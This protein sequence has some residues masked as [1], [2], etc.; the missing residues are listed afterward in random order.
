MATPAEME[1][2]FWK[3]LKSDMTMMLG[4]DGVEDGHTRPMTAQTEEEGGPIWFFTSKDNGIV[5]RLSGT[6][7]A[8]ATF[9]SKGHDL[10]ATV[11]GRLGLELDRAV[12]DRLW[13]P[14]AAAWYEEGK[15]DPKLALLRLDPEQAEIW[16]DGSSLVAGVKALLGVDPKKDY[17]DK[18]AEVDLGRG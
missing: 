5:E 17:K 2:R 8:I 4:L 13:N 11:H 3:A 6:D 15:D 12:V 1:K 7:R 18:V 10:F 14:F 9:V 16:L